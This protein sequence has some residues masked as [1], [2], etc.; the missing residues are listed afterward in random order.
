M[1]LVA[2]ESVDAPIAE[3]LRRDGHDALSIAEFSPSVSD[4]VVLREANA[5]KALLMTADKDFGEMVFD[6]DRQPRVSC[7][8][9]CPV[10]PPQRRPHWSPVSSASTDRNSSVP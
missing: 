6:S 5:R 9:D 4:E 7:F 2:G 10:F 1:N 8:R 3:R